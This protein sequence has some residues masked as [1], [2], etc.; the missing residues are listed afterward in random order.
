MKRRIG[1]AVLTI[2]VIALVATGTALA[3]HDAVKVAKKDGVGSYL[4]DAKGMTL[5]QFKNDHHGMSAC[6]GPCIDNWPPF[7]QD[8]GEAVD[9]LAITD[10][11]TIPRAD[12]KKQIGYKGMPLYYFIKDKKPGDTAGQGV[13]DVWSVVNP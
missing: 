4:T 5:Y 1:R 3:A 12:G 6:E 9:G 10:F 13:K 11:G 8:L 7:F 2:M